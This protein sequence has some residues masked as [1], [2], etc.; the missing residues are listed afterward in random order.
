[1]AW[2]TFA[3]LTTPTLP[4]LDGNFTL[5]S[6]L[7]NIPCT[8]SGTNTLTLTSQAGAATYTQYQAGMRLQGV[9]TATNSGA[10]NAQLGTLPLVPV[11]KDSPAGPVVLSGAEIVNLTAFALLYDPALNSGGGGWHLQNSAGGLSG[12]SLASLNVG[13]L[14]AGSLSAGT[15]AL[16]QVAFGSLSATIGSIGTL[17]SSLATL[18]SLAMGAGAPLLRLNS[19]LTSAVFT[20]LTPG[21]AQF[22]TLPWAGVQPFDNILLGWS[23]APVSS[24]VFTPYAPAAGSVILAAFNP[25][26]NVTITLNTVNFRLTNLGWT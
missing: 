21:V 11:Y 5:L 25:L 26:S 4:E 22:A 20:T 17:V 16:A 10:V 15:F 23:L 9:A 24:I 13:L 12:S 14:G 6:Y 3:A 8:V 2:T 18:G 19:T 1:M 7:I